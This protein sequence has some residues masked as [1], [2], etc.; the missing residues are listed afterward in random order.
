VLNSNPTRAAMTILLFVTLFFKYKER[1]REGIINDIVKERNGNNRS[2]V[3]GTQSMNGR[4]N[5]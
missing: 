2:H 3:R 1:D 4:T 5:E